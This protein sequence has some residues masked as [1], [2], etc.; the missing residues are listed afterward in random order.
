M[1]V[2]LISLLWGIVALFWMVLALVP[3]LGW[4]NWLVIPFAALG[5][6]IAAAG[7]LFTHPSKR[8]RAWAGL[9]LNGIVVVVGMIRLSLG[10][11]IL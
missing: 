7:I 8:G 11:G 6:V 1:H 2:G 10:G 5:A 9:V 4:A 3:L